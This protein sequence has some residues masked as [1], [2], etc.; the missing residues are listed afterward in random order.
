MGNLDSQIRC[1]DPLRADKPLQVLTDHWDN[2]SVIKSYS[3]SPQDGAQ[4]EPTPPVFI[5]GSWDKT[6]RVWTWDPAVAGGRWTSMFVLRGHAE[7]VW[8]AQI[9]EP[10]ARAVQE[11]TAANQGKYLTSSADL[12]IRLFHG[13][14]LHAVYAGHIDVVR[15]LELLPILPT[16]HATSTGSPPLYPAEWLFATTSNDGTVRVW[17]LDPRRSPTPGNGGEALRVLRGH[18]SLVYD[19]AAYLEHATSNPKLV[20]S[21]E[22]GTF[23]VWNW[24]SAELLETVAVPA[25]SVWCIAVLPQTQDVV[26]GCSDSLVRVYSRQPP[27][28][29]PA[30]DSNLGGPALSASEAAAQA[31]KAEQVQIQHSIA[32]Q[33]RQKPAAAQ[34]QTKGQGE[35][36]EG[37]H[38]DFV[39][40]I[41]VSDDAEP[42]P[43]PIN[44]ADDRQQAALDFVVLHKL[45]ESY[46]ERIVEFIDLVLG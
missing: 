3:S 4:Q 18:T 12:F 36:F 39:L 38:Y 30:S 1:F 8:G 13:E 42:L 14:Q 35:V 37:K 16:Q 22:D 5:S 15:S 34:D 20:S 6:A 46:G 11:Q 17:S 33:A 31:A 26:V 29:R 2:V 21:G 28:T 25:T 24:D 9:V 32:I 23:R 19:L 43:L 41:D 40:R 45:P 10:P 7:A 44:R 27:A